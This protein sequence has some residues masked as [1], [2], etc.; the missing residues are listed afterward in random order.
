MESVGKQK[1]VQVQKTG[2]S[3]YSQDGEKTEAVSDVSLQ[4]FAVI[5]DDGT[6]VFNLDKE[7]IQLGEVL[8]VEISS[9]AFS[10]KKSYVVACSKYIEGQSNLFIVNTKMELIADFI[11]KGTSKEGALSVSWTNDEKYM[12]RRESASAKKVYV[13][14]VSESLTKEFGAISQDKVTSFAFSPHGSD[15]EKPY[16]LL[17]G[18]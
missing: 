6:A 15:D 2:I 11:W 16:F 7:V 13:Y 10:P 8:K 5:T 3:F 1:V 14:E 17:V 4:P 12:A 18:A 9:V